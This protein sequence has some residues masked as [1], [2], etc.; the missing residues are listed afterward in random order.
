[1]FAAPQTPRRNQP[2]VPVNIQGEE[3]TDD[4]GNV[5]VHVTIPASVARTVKWS[6]KMTPRS[7]A[8]V[9]SPSASPAIV[10]LQLNREG[11]ARTSARH[12]GRSAPPSP[13]LSPA[14]PPP[15][16]TPLPLPT[17]SPSPPR[18]LQVAP[19]RVPQVAPPRVSC[20]TSI[21]SHK[22][23]YFTGRPSNL[24]SRSHLSVPK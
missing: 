2:T 19:H 20:N 1:M 24:V 13:P 17:L 11:H 18:V 14:Q 7:A 6:F 8:L 16:P 5:H 4:N 15:L 22:L 23:T 9:R 10:P 3:T 12:R 21:L